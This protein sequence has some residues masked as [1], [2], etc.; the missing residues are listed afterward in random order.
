MFPRKILN[1]NDEKRCLLRGQCRGVINGTS[2]EFSQLWDIRWPV[3]T[4]A[5]DIVRIRYQETTS[6]DIEDFMYAAVTVCVNQ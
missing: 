3:R 6:E 2:L 1:Y 5:G 4:L